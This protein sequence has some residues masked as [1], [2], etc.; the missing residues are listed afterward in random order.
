M[1]LNTF[2][3]TSYVHVAIANLDVPHDAG[4]ILCYPTLAPVAT[5]GV[6]A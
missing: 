3:T 2:V 5:I 6:E 4:V 1:G